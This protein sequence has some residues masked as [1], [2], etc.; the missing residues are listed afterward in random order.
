MAAT[1]REEV[2]AIEEIVLEAAKCLWPGMKGQ[3]CGSYRRGKSSS[4]D[5]DVLLSHPAMAQAPPLSDLIMLLHDIGFLTADLARPTARDA[6]YGSSDEED[7]NIASSSHGSYMGIGSLPRAPWEVERLLWLAL[8]QHNSRNPRCHLGR[9]PV[10]LVQS[11]AWEW[12]GGYE[13]RIDIKIYPREQYSYAVRLLHIHTHAHTHALTLDVAT[14]NA[15]CTLHP[16]PQLCYFT[17]SSHFNRSMRHYANKCGW[18][19][20]DHGL[21]PAVRVS[22]HRLVTERV[23]VPAFSERDIFDALNLQYRVRTFVAM[24]P[25]HSTV[26]S[27][28]HTSRHPM[29]ATAAT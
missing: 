9:L 26:R 7:Y 19:L 24:P 18:S 11:L 27:H 8:S 5:V 4:G 1:H 21:V 23:S 3:A 29:S 12:I 6:L 20:S 2:A 10:E 22:G 17:G 15:D 25:V 28:T 14:G 16:A 13:R